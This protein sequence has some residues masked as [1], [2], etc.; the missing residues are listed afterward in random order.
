MLSTT[1]G[2]RLAQED[3][4]GELALR[5][6]DVLF[7]LLALLL[8][9]RRVFLRLGD[10]EHQIEFD[11][12]ANDVGFGRRLGF[13]LEGHP[14]DLLDRFGVALG[15]GERR[16][17]AV[18]RAVELLLGIELGLGAEGARQGDDFLDDGDFLFGLGVGQF[19][20]VLRVGGEG[21]GF[22]AGPRAGRAAARALR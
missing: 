1:L 20:A 17:A 11:G 13:H 8:L 19:R 6:G 18:E 14:G 15:D 9:A 16:R 3:F 2:G 7:E 10:I 22:R 12:G 4:V 5:V 21:D